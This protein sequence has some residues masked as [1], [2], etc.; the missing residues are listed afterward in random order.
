MVKIVFTHCYSLMNIRKLHIFF[1]SAKTGHVIVCWFLC[2][3]P[4]LNLKLFWTSEQNNFRFSSGKFGGKHK[5]QQTISCQ[6]LAELNK[7]IWSC[8]IFIKLYIPSNLIIDFILWIDCECSKM[9]NHGLI[10][11]YFFH[12]SSLYPAP[13]IELYVLA[14]LNFIFEF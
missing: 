13:Y 3:P 7:K 8:L 6:V 11:G 2:F 12:F 14:Y 5:N 4:E 10:M 1:N 9:L